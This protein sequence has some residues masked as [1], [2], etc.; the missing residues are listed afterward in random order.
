M[1]VVQNESADYRISSRIVT[2]V[3]EII[4]VSSYATV[5]ALPE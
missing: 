3:R 2:Y 4:Q 1:Q 5:V